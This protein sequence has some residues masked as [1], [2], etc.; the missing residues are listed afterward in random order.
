[1]R[2]CVLTACIK[3]SKD[4]VGRRSLGHKIVMTS[5]KMQIKK[6][7]GRISRQKCI[8]YIN[9][10]CLLAERPKIYFNITKVDLFED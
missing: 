6:L 3:C 9:L 5:L 1:M 7:F 4:R 2:A 8:N 10:H